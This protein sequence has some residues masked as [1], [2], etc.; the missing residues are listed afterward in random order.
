MQS[1]DPATAPSP[2]LPVRPEWLAR[3]QEAILEPDLPIVDPHHHLVDREN[4]GRYLQEEGLK[5]IAEDV[6]NLI[7]RNPIPALLAGVGVGFLIGR[8]T[9]RGS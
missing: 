6:T 7:R 1:A 5:G 8:I 4:T 2:H 9:T 3:R